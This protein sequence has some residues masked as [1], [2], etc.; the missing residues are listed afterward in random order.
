MSTIRGSNGF[1]DYYD[2]LDEDQIKFLEEAAKA[3]EDILAKDKFSLSE[4]ANVSPSV[5]GL[6]AEVPKF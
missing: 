3:Q 4:F 2:K 6:T 5:P 1:Y